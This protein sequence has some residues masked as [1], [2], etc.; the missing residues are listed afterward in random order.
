VSFFSAMIKPPFRYLVVE[1]PPKCHYNMQDS[2]QNQ[3]SH[4]FRHL[5]AYHKTPGQNFVPSFP[6]NPKNPMIL[7]TW[8]VQNLV[9]IVQKIVPFPIPHVNPA[10]KIPAFEHSLLQPLHQDPEV[11]QILNQ[12]SL[13]GLLRSLPIPRIPRRCLL[14]KSTVE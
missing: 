11:V 8:P 3:K 1:K 5:P 13:F 7:D 4:A 14:Y 12:L 10:R 6:P 9:P 2:C